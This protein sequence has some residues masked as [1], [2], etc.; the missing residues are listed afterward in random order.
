MIIVLEQTLNIFLFS[1]IAN[2]VSNSSSGFANKATI[3]VLI[4]KR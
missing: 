3:H 4:A 2:M 1:K